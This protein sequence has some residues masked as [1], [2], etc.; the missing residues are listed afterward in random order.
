MA[1]SGLDAATINTTLYGEDSEWETLY[2]TIQGDIKTHFDGVTEAICQPTIELP[3]CAF[4][5]LTY[6]QWLNGSVLKNPLSDQNVTSTGYVLNYGNL[7]SGWITP[8][9]NYWREQNDITGMQFEEFEEA[10]NQTYYAFNISGLYNGKKFQDVLL[11]PQDIWSFVP[12]FNQYLRSITIN[13]GLSGVLTLR[14]PREMI[15]GYYDPLIG[16]LNETP[17]W[18]GGDNTTS[19]FLSLADPPTHPKNNRVSFFT[20]QDDYQMT[21]TYGQWLG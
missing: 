17:V 1:L 21:R 3:T 8:E 7:A 18:M 9:Y 5:N 11:Y 12:S 10:I 16:T 4:S 6:S 15:D 20:G 13:F 2:N 14:S 19:A